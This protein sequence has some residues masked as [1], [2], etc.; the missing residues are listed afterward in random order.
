MALELAVGAADADTEDHVAISTPL[1]PR[2]ATFD[3]TTLRWT[4]AFDQ[5]GPHV[6]AFIAADDHALS[7]PLF[8]EGSVTIDVADVNRAPRITSAPVTRVFHEGETATFSVRAEDSDE[9]QRLIVSLL[10]LNE[11]PTAASVQTSGDFRWAIPLLTRGTFRFRF[12]ATDDDAPPLSAERQEVLE[13]RYTNLFP[14]LDEIAPR[15][16]SEGGRVAFTAS[17]HP[18]DP[19]EPDAVA[20][21]GQTLTYSLRSAGADELPPEARLNPVTGAFTWDVGCRAAGEYLVEIKVTD[22]GEP[23]RSATR[24]VPITVSA[25]NCAPAFTQLSRLEDGST[26]VPGAG[27]T[28]RWEVAEDSTLTVVV[29]GADQDGDVLTYAA[30][31]KPA[32]ATFNPL[33]RTFAWRPSCA[34]A[35][36]SPYTVELTVSDGAAPAISQ[37]FAI[38]VRD[39]NCPPRLT[40]LCSTPLVAGDVSAVECP[41]TEGARLSFSAEGTDPDGDPLVWTATLPSRMGNAFEPLTRAFSWRPAC[42]DAGV[43]SAVFSARDPSGLSATRTITFTIVSGACRPEFKSI[44]FAH[45]LD[46]DVVAV[47]DADSEKSFTADEAQAVA[48]LIRADSPEGL[49]VRYTAS[50]LPEGAALVPDVASGTA[51]ITWTP[52]CRQKGDSEVLLVA[53]DTAASADFLT[54]RV[55]VAETNCAP[56]LTL[57][58]PRA[59]AEDETLVVDLA[60]TA[61][62]PDGDALTDFAVAWERGGVAVAQPASATL[63]AS[64]LFVWTPAY[65]EAGSWALVFH[66]DDRAPLGSRTAQARVAVTVAD[67][68]RA[69]VVAFSPAGGGANGDAFSE[70]EGGTLA[71]TVLASDPDTDAVT[72]SSFVWFDAAG[73]PMARPAGAGLERATGAFHW[74]LGY[75][76]AGAYQVVFTVRDPKGL[77]TAK[78]AYLTVLDVDT[79]PRLSVL[80]AHSP[81]VEGAAPA[82]AGV[83]EAI[84]DDADLVTMNVLW[85]R[86]RCTEA[87]SD[88]ADPR[89]LP[90]SASFATSP[91]AGLARATFSWTPSFR[92]ADGGSEYC[93]TV[94]ALD[95]T[96]PT[97]AAPL[98]VDLA[99]R[100]TD[101]VPALAARPSS[102][103]TLRE[104][105]ISAVVVLTAGDEDSDALAL[106]ALQK[107]EPCGSNSLQFTALESSKTD[108]QPSSGDGAAQTTFTFRPGYADQGAWC[109]A[110]TASDTGPGSASATVK[111]DFTVSDVDLAPSLT[112]EPAALVAAEG[113]DMTRVRGEAVSADPDVVDFVLRWRRTSCTTTG[114]ESTDLAAL[115]GLARAART[116]GPGAATLALDWRP[117]YT[118]AGEWCFTFIAYD[119]DGTKTAS[120]AVPVTVLDTVLPPPAPTGLAATPGD[121]RITLNWTAAPTANA[122]EIHRGEISGGPYTLMGASIANTF[123]DADTTL[124]NGAVYYYVV[125]GVNSA[126]AGPASAQAAGN[127]ILPPPTGVQA[128]AQSIA[129]QIALSWAGVQG[130]TSYTLYRSTTSG[131]GYAAMISTSLWSYTDTGLLNGTTYHFVVRATRGSVASVDSGQ[132]SATTVMPAPASLRIT[133]SGTTTVDLAWNTVA[134]A[135]QYLVFRSLVAGSGYTLATSATGTTAQVP[136]L[137]SGTTYYFVAQAQ[138][139]QAA[140]ANSNEVFSTTVLPA[141]ATLTATGQSGRI[142]LDWSSVPGASGYILLV[143]TTSGSG[144]T[145]LATPATNSYTHT[146]LLNGVRRYYLVRATTTQAT[147]PNSTEASAVTILPAPG[148]LAARSQGRDRIDLSWNPVTGATGYRVLRSTTSGTGYVQVA[149]TAA[150]VVLQSDTS[151]LQPATTY[152]YVVRAITSV[153]VSANSNEASAPTD[154]WPFGLDGPLVV[155]SGETY[156]VA[157]GSMHDW[158]SVTI[159]PGGTLLVGEG[160]DWTIIG[161]SGNLSLGGQIVARGGAHLGGTFATRAPSLSGQRDGEALSLELAQPAGGKGGDIGYGTAVGDTLNV[162]GAAG[163]GNGGGGAGNLFAIDGAC[164]TIGNGN[165]NHGYAAALGKGGDG[166]AGG[167]GGPSGGVGADVYGGDGG[168]GVVGN[169]CAHPVS[170]GSAG[171]GGSR[172]HHGQGLYLAVKGWSAGAGSIDVRGQ[173]G[174]RGGNGIAG[175]VWNPYDWAGSAGGGGGSGGGGGRV[176][177]RHGGPFTNAIRVLI[178]GGNGGVAGSGSTSWASCAPSVNS[179]GVDGESGDRGTSDVHSTLPWTE[180]NRGVDVATVQYLLADGSTVFAGT[181]GG[182]IYR[183]NDGGVSWALFRSGLNEGTIN[184]IAKHPTHPGEYWAGGWGGL[185]KTTNGGESWTSVYAQRIGS[186]A[187]DTSSD[188]PVLYIAGDISSIG[189]SFN[190]GATFSFINPPPG[191]GVRLL[192]L[193]PVARRIHAVF[194]TTAGEF[195]LTTRTWVSEVNFGGSTLNYIGVTPTSPL[196]AWISMAGSWYRSTNAGVSWNFMSSLT[197]TSGGGGVVAVAADPAAPNTVYVSSGGVYKTNDNGTN[198]STLSSGLPASPR[199]Q[200]VAISSSRVLVGTADSVF[201]STSGGS[202]WTSGAAGLAQVS[203][204]RLAFDPSDARIVH[205]V[206]GIAAYRSTDR[207]LTWTMRS[208]GLPVSNTGTTGAFAAFKTAGATY[209]YLGGYRS[210]DGG[211]SWATMSMAAGAQAYSPDPGDP[212]GMTVYAGTTNGVY[213]T[214][215]GGTSWSRTW[216]ASVP[217]PNDNNLGAV[218]AANGIV[219]AGTLSAGVFKS[220]DGGGTWTRTSA[221]P[222]SYYIYSLG[223]DQAAPATVYC[224]FFGGVGI[225][226]TTNE[227]ATWAM[228]PGAPMW[229]TRGIL[230]QGD[231]VYA[232]TATQYLTAGVYKSRDGGQTWYYA[233]LGLFNTNVWGL[234]ADPADP[235]LIIAGT[236]GNGFFRSTTGGE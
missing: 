80:S 213:K 169:S 164:G 200:A 174:G 117:D 185:F 57:A 82:S 161:I 233:S 234:A 180:A 192:A 3:G 204:T 182:G 54:L 114:L 66:V 124:V 109:F 201:S 99:V 207:G 198:W 71:F 229:E 137:T 73:A 230:V 84:D 43:Y 216:P 21:G 15:T 135:S 235:Q 75:A 228:L 98:L 162:G 45:G 159:E 145:Q 91:G 6:I 22:D 108:F 131:S 17:G 40:H 2:G 171:G 94:N 61:T 183:S 197:T 168:N 148:G 134:G 205:A 236:M 222:N 65:D 97:A 177:V 62:D 188:P 70:S 178:D 79:V 156:P 232:A 173:G 151:D 136:S 78:T 126:G 13:V 105:E 138:T 10:D 42:T 191:K 48:W 142:Q 194:N 195:D 20:E 130:A 140:S 36:G 41:G 220:T 56:S 175:E 39:V 100:E 30:R 218:A 85:R 11:P 16:A 76:D 150:P 116:S 103:Q 155:R 44:S 113:A 217:G 139:L 199:A 69:P 37:V 210:T 115:P 211:A 95:S 190:N 226:K 24:R 193:D 81:P 53:S 132:A 12:T 23:A 227:G 206:G 119:V 55:H 38:D 202:T 184:V 107:Q 112:V 102:A 208:N 49:A 14:S 120:R 157:A 176:V 143:S 203:V 35:A 219:Y 68:N 172:G 7:P 160:T 63:S 33:T 165:G 52:S 101:T 96:G 58:T 170:T 93:I 127:P 149:T 212:T 147:S 158:S 83:V 215:T 89:G 1:L 224:G 4:P 25:A 88:S 196:T 5:S 133:A 72:D 9:G 122:Y 221:N 28:P 64:G 223:L 74:T 92:A 47:A 67:S 32:G 123:A 8:A 31:E 214:T 90:G 186:I 179:N 187:F 189:E 125:K 209:L 154:T 60:Q 19:A 152:F 163:S 77:A 225:A 51:R 118:A 111:I 128:V 34:A 27:L 153:A 50:G 129:G 26:V 106:T 18:A 86:G 146:G 110:F 29:A 231:T 59:L 46:L 144:Y 166:G 104:G 87:G 167:C 141:P 181:Y 121:R